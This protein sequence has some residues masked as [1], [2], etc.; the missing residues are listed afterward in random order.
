MPHA[1]PPDVAMATVSSKGFP[2][3]DP[4]ERIEMV[5]APG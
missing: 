5:M 1:L 4:V 3:T 2:C